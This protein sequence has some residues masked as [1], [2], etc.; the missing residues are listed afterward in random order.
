MRCP[1][2]QKF[3][4]SS[5]RRFQ[6]THMCQI[7]KENQLMQTCEQVRHEIFLSALHTS[8]WS[9]EREHRSPEESAAPPPKDLSSAACWDYYCCHHHDHPTH[10][11]T[12]RQAHCPRQ[13]E[14]T[15]PGDSDHL[16]YVIELKRASCCLS[17]W[18]GMTVF[19]TTPVR[20]DFRTG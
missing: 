16:R 11:S 13:R 12:E 5:Q 17:P 2:S 7:T 4:V 10:G 8:K 9:K 15:A 14:P 1:S 20:I 18:T 3:I 6:W 19:F